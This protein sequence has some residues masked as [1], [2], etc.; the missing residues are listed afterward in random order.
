MAKNNGLYSKI[1]SICWK[2]F[3]SLFLLICMAG[4]QD[5][6]DD[7]GMQMPEPD[8]KFVEETLNLPLDKKEYT[9]DVESNLPWRVKTSA[10]WIELLSS[11][12]Q[13]SGSFSISVSKNT[14]VVSREA[15]IIGWIIEGNDTKLKVKQEGMGI[16]LKKRALKVNSKGAE[17]VI[18]FTTLV[19]YT[20][21]LSEGCDW[22]HVTDGQVITP[23]IINES[24]LKL[25]ID[26]N[27]NGNEEERSASLYLKGANG[28]VDELVITQDNKPLEDI[29]YLR[30]FYEN[31]NGDNW[32]KKWNFDAELKTDAENWPGVTVVGG[33]VTEIDFSSS[34]LLK[35]NIEGQI[36]PLCY[37][38]ELTSLKF[39]HQK[40]EGIPEEIGLLTRLQTLWVIE[41]GAGGNLPE[42]LENNAGLTSLNISNHPTTTPDGFNNTFTGNL[43]MLLNVSGIITIKAYCNN[44]SGSLPVIPL[45]E[46]N[47]PTTWNSLKE[48]IVYSNGFTGNIPYGYG[49]VI[50]KS[51]ASGIFRVADNQLSGQIPADLKAW[52]QYEKRKAAWI[53]N[54]NSLTE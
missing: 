52:S 27:M 40:I 46:N 37:L 3:Y 45:D 12:G 34:A 42:S 13:G 18:P 23:G 11:N 32:I 24:F 47:M 4:C 8:L 36:T 21:E 14:D 53:L 5:F 54:G 1:R 2:A 25:K 28:V 41:C 31:A 35:N 33:R 48:F 16:A 22:I 26:P 39:K 15:E 7:S 44:F 9:V 17:E 29:D 20:Y 49:I 38:S 43:D 51:G 6:T 50:E 10:S 19:S 30:M